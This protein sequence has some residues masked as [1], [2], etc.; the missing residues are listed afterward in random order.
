LEEMAQ[1]SKEAMLDPL[2]GFRP[3]QV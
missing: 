1:L 2:P 3:T